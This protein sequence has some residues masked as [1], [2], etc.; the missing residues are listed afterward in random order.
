[1]TNEND[2][3]PK[4]WFRASLP[5]KADLREDVWRALRAAGV[6]PQPK[7]CYA[8][9]ARV[10]ALQREVDLFYVEGLVN[11]EG[12]VFHHAWV[13]TADGVDHDV[14]LRGDVV[15]VRVDLVL[16]SREAAERM[17][18]TGRY[19]MWSD[20]IELPVVRDREGRIVR[21]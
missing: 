14:T 10:V 2:A 1:M 17:A 19:G 9:A 7:Q 13:R 21:R 11:R 3:L 5:R 18:E 15:P 4:G 12:H 20:A 8:N 16:A 6:R